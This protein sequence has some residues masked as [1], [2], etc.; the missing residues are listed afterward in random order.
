[1]VPEKSEVVIIN[2]EELQLPVF[3]I[4]NSVRFD[5]TVDDLRLMCVSALPTKD[6]E[7]ARLTYYYWDASDRWFQAVNI[8]KVKPAPLWMRF[9]V[10]NQLMIANYQLQLLDERPREWRRA[11]KDMGLLAEFHTDN[12]HEAK[13]SLHKC[14]TSLKLVTWLKTYI[15]RRWSY[16]GL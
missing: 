11:Y 8:A 5:E 16:Q 13:A 10:G 1:M 3:R 4:G 15:P 6:G 9:L 2:L 12:I 7:P 14:D